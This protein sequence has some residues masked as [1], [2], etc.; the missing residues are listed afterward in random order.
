MADFPELVQTAFEIY[1][2]LQ[3]CWDSMGGNYLGKNTSTLFEYFRLFD[4]DNNEQLVVVSLIQR[5]DVARTQLI[6]QKLKQ[7][8][9]ASSRK[10]AWGFF[11]GQNFLVWH[12]F[13]EVI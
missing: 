8:R 11:I 6:S 10:K 4:L 3:D 13:A 12:L 5:M 9:E 2:M 1:F 7:Q